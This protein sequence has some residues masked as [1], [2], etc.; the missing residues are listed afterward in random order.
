VKGESSLSDSFMIRLSGSGRLEV[1]SID[2][3]NNIT[4]RGVAALRH[5]LHLRVLKLG[6]ARV[7]SAL[8]E[9]RL[10]GLT[11]L[12]LEQSDVGDASLE[13]LRMA[14]R[15]ELLDLSGTDTTLRRRS[16][17]LT[18]R[19]AAADT[20]LLSDPPPHMRMTTDE[21]SSARTICPM[22]QR[23]GVLRERSC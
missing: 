16:Q 7:H 14:H 12:D 3:A 9:L 20:M 15:L 6:S 19:R 21:V 1:L 22:D 17:I 4:D 13:C 10:D 5:C 18:S 2:T 11:D 8:Q 23:A